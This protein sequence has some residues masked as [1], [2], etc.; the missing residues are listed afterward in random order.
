[1]SPMMFDQFILPRLTKLVQEIKGL[2]AFCIKHSDGNMTSLMESL[3]STGVDCVHPFEPVAGM[4]LRSA[5][6]QWGNRIC[7]MGN[8]DCGQ[9]MCHGRPEEVEEAV[10]QCIRDAGGGGGYILSSSNSTHSSVKPE[11]F[12]AMVNAGKKHGRY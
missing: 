11:N 10:R 3:I 7:I 2:N 12:L 4:D 5:K 8:V 9:L 6:A 1:M